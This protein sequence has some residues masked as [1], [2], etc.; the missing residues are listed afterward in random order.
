MSNLLVVDVFESYYEGRKTPFPA[1][2]VEMA[3]QARR[4]ERKPQGKVEEPE[5]QVRRAA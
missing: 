3:A 2:G 5:R 4:D 1:E